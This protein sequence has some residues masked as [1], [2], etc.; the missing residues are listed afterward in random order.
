MHEECRRVILLGAAG[1]AM[2]ALAGCDS[3]P[4]PAAT[5]TLLNNDA[6]HQAVKSLVSAVDALNGDVS[7]FESENW[8]DVVPDVRTAAVNVSDAATALKKA[9]G[10]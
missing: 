1:A 8:R 10:Y 4:K 5:A 3:E 7:R 9:L 6:V 2:A